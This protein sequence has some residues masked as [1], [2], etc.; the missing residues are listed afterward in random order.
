MSFQ[1]RLVE[2]SLAS[3]PQANFA[4]QLKIWQARVEHELSARLPAI[5]VQPSRLHEAIRY[6]VLGGGKRVRPTL[7]YA[8]GAALGIPE[9][10]LDA[11]ACAVELIHAYSLVHDDLPA[12]DND[13]LRRGRPTCH[14]AFD[15][16]TAILVGD[17]LQVLAFELLAS[18]SGAPADPA[19]RLKLVQLLA[20]ASGTNGMAGGQALDLAAIGRKLSVADVEEMHVRKTGALIHAAVMMAAACAPNLSETTWRALDDYARAIGLA[21]QIQDDLLD[22]EGDVAVIGKATGADRALDKPTYPSVAGVE[23]S[24]QRMNELHARALAAL[25]VTGLQA[26]PLAAMSDWLVLRKY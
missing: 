13:D 19:V 7:V 15:E 17:S 10:T 24:R 6:S 22:V 9:T 18:G 25:K 20:V 23:P 1:P 4:V 3:G 21:F 5:D 16:A 8:T 2:P 26:A 12:M 14:K 11:A